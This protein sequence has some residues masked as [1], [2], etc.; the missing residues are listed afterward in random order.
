MR[1]LV[2]LCLTTL[3]LAGIVHFVTILAIPRLAPKDGW[4]RLAALAGDE[5]ITVLPPASPDF[6]AVP[7]L[8]PAIAYAVCPFDLGENGFAISAEM[9][10][11]YWSVAFHTRQGTVFYAVNGEAATSSALDI[12]L[13]NARQL[14]QFRIEEPEPAEQVLYIEAPEDTGMAVFRALVA[15]AA[16]RGEIEQVLARTYCA[17]LPERAADPSLTPRGDEI[18]LPEPRPE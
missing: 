6:D 1:R 5:G 16:E 11:H 17:P 15:H 8:D 3:A 14:R 7:L 18:P 2:L 9:P 4:S 10:A 12:E 13:R